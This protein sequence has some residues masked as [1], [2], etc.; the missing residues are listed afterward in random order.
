MVPSWFLPPVGIIVADV[1]SSGHPALAPIAYACLVF[2]ILAYA[3]M[4]PM[5]I[6]RFIFHMKF[7]MRRSQ[8]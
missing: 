5:M 3:V 4:M 8:H 1:S 2:G 6:Y 7:Q